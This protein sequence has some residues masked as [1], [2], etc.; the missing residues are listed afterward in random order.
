MIAQLLAPMS[1]QRMSAPPPP[2]QTIRPEVKLGGPDNY[3]VNV[4]TLAK[5]TGYITAGGGGAA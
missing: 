5:A 2:L 1:C 4:V 3:N